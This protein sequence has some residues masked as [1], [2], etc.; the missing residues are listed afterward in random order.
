[1]M[2]GTGAFGNIDFDSA[3][4]RRPGRTL[5]AGRANVTVFTA[6]ASGAGGLPSHILIAR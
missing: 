5:A 4:R 1:M 6:L 3:R 2:R